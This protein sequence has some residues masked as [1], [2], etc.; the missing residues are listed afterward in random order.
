[1]ALSKDE[2]TNLQVLFGIPEEFIAEALKML[3]SQ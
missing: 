3:S 2:Q 1:M